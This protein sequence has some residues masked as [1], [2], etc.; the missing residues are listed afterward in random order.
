MNYRR[1]KQL[2]DGKGAKQACQELE[3]LFE[4]GRKGEP[5]GLK[6]DELSI[7]DVAE[8]FVADGREWVE[9]LKSGG[10]TVLESMGGVDT[11]AFANISRQ[12][13]FSFFMEAYN[14]PEFE[15][16]ALIPTRQTRIPSGEL[17]PGS[18]G[19][20]DA[21][22]EDETIHELHPYPRISYGEDWLEMPKLEKRGFIVGVSKELVWADRTGLFQRDMQNLGYKLRLR[23]EKQAVD[24]LIG[25]T[26]NYT[27]QDTAFNTYQAA[28]PWINTHAN[29]VTNWVDFQDA[30]RLFGNM[31]DPNTG[32]PIV[33]RPTTV[34]AT[35]GNSWTIAMVANATA[36]NTGDITAAPG[37]QT[38][39]R[40]PVPSFRLVE[41]QYVYNR[42]Q[43]QKSVS[44]S[45]AAQY[46]YL[47][48][49]AKAF[50]YLEGW[51][52]EVTQAP[53]NSSEEFNND[54][55]FQFKASGYGVYA[56]LD[57]RYMVENTN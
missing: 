27:R 51:P 45:N 46:W 20:S 3:G 28:T 44:A 53:K 40:N 47:G 18:T 57:P 23:R 21:D 30:Y 10:A 38:T 29:P 9:N 48:D 56:V 8:A 4:L 39:T 36:I 42:L 22:D 43:T 52:I 26:N 17:I 19:L 13:A 12:M 2:Y 32:E 35:P 54:I 41:S 31:T 49:L 37:I 16:S 1:L 55:L 33:V 14:A 11:T 24:V 34:V 7:R 5:G 25:A 50:V 6:A 15:I